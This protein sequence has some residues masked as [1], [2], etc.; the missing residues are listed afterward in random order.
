MG[1]VRGPWCSPSACVCERVLKYFWTRFRAAC[2]SESCARAV[3]SL[4]LSPSSFSRAAEPKKLVQYR[5]RTSGERKKR[6]LINV[7][8]RRPG[9]V[10]MCGHRHGHSHTNQTRLVVPLA[11][12]AAFG[13]RAKQV[14]PKLPG[15]CAKSLVGQGTSLV[16]IATTERKFAMGQRNLSTRHQSFI[17]AL[18]CARPVALA[19]RIRLWPCPMIRPLVRICVACHGAVLS[20]FLGWF[21]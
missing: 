10:R 11:Y 12:C 4:S 2:K 21:V 17:T 16:T 15:G 1:R 13:L 9:L 20:I 5:R 6:R 14:T 7:K 19:G 18:S 8:K 3:A